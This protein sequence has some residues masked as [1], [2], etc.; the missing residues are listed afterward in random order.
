[1]LSVQVYGLKAARKIPYKH[2]KSLAKKTKQ[3]L[4]DLIQA[5]SDDV[6]IDNLQ[7]SVFS[8]GT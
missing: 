3:V 6:T 5:S 8:L 1:M 7:P 4:D 2:A